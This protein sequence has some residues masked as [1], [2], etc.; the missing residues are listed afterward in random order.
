M[1]KPITIRATTRDDCPAIAAIADATGLFPAEAL[2]EMI[3]PYLEELSL[4]MWLTAE[5]GGEPAGFCFVEPERLTNGTWNLLAISTTPDQQSHGIGRRLVEHVETLLRKRGDRV[6]IVE[7]T[8]APDQD[9]TRAFYLK[10]GFV[11]EAR[12]REF[13]DVGVDKVVFWKHL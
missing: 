9:R 11:E 3:A 2:D 7:T 1:N 8:N 4:D 6:L 10:N 12:L 13:W 5:A